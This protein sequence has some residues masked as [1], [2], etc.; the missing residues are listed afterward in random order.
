VR[1]VLRRVYGWSAADT[2]LLMLAVRLAY[3]RHAL[4]NMADVAAAEGVTLPCGL[5]ALASML[6]PAASGRPDSAP[7]LAA[8]RRRIAADAAG[9]TVAGAS[10]DTLPDGTSAAAALASISAATPAGDRAAMVVHAEYASEVAEV[11][12]DCDSLSAAAARL[13]ATVSAELFRDSDARL[14]EVAVQHTARAIAK[15]QARG[16]LALPSAAATPAATMAGAASAA[17]EASAD[18]ARTAG[19][20]GRSAVALV[21]QATLLLRAL[22]SRLHGWTDD[23]LRFI[24]P[25]GLD[26]DGAAASGSASQD[27]DQ[28]PEPT[29]AG[30]CAL[31]MLLRDVLVPPAAAVWDKLELLRSIAEDVEPF[32]GGLTEGA[33]DLF[34]DMLAPAGAPAPC[35]PQPTLSALGAAVVATIPAPA[36]I[37]GT[38]VASAPAKAVGSPAWTFARIAA[39]L[40]R[41]LEQCE[42]QRARHAASGGSGSPATFY[43][44]Q[45]L[46]EDIVFHVLPTPLPVNDVTARTACP[47]RAFGVAAGADR[48]VGDGGASSGVTDATAAAAPT[49][50]QQR[51][52]IRCIHRLA[53]HYVAALTSTPLSH[54]CK[55]ARMLV[56]G[57]LLAYADTTARIFARDGVSPL[58]LVL[59]GADSVLGEEGA[60]ATAAEA[61]AACS[62][63]GSVAF[64]VSLVS[65]GNENFADAVSGVYVANP[66]ALATRARLLRY[67]DG[68]NAQQPGRPRCEVPFLFGNTDAEVQAADPPGPEFLPAEGSGTYALVMRLVSVTGRESVVPYALQAHTQA[69]GGAGDVPGELAAAGRMKRS[70]EWVWLSMLPSYSGALMQ[71]F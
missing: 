31:P 60:A 64:G 2:K 52:T 62:E 25:L 8:L 48:G 70:C 45:A 1:Y 61:T 32:A 17:D 56:M 9:V 28:N 14:V 6:P 10:P 7:F 13:A 71:R 43:Q 27:V 34:V 35:Y 26:S 20:G 50:V 12:G 24:T 3:L 29:A 16:I 23:S 44:V 40:E 38:N 37:G 69:N 54:E 49:L 63:A 15:L 67:S 53:C 11:V 65:N 58:A 47:W 30:P 39:T 66:S 57:S 41:T 18:A 36:S 19:E 42:A 59:S 22:Q 33:P 46:I 51:A 55:G 68:M 5:S 4:G 21:T